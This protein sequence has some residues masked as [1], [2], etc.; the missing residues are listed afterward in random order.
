MY[1]VLSAD[2]NMRMWIGKNGENSSAN[3]DAAQQF[4]VTTTPITVT[5]PS[6]GQDISSIQMGQ[7]S[8]TGTM[9]VHSV[10]KGD[11]LLIDGPANNSQNWSDDVE[12]TSGV[13]SGSEANKAFDGDLSTQASTSGTNADVIQITFDPS[14]KDIS[15]F[16]VYTSL[17]ANVA[18]N[19]TSGDIN[20][21][22]ADNVQTNAGAWT[23][24]GINVNSN[25]TSLRVMGN[26]GGAA[27]RISAIRVDDKLLVDSGTEWD[28]SEVW[29][30]GMSGAWT[31]ASP[32]ANLY[33][34]DV[35]YSSGAQAE[36]N[37]LVTALSVDS[38]SKLTEV[39]KIE[40]YSQITGGSQFFD[41]IGYSDDGSTEVFNQKI[42]DTNN[43]SG[44]KWY[45]ISGLSNVDIQRIDIQNG[46]QTTRRFAALKING[47]ILVDAGTLGGNGFYLPFN[48]AESGTKWSNYLSTNYQL[49]NPGQSFD[50][51]TSTYGEG[52][53]VPMTILL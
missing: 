25:V 17:Q 35:E 42:N 6:D 9:R 51:N 45:V 19:V 26:A 46:D 39:T 2:T 49:N 28:Q 53:G 14:L 44:E 30:A 21:L 13:N 40:I 20:S 18:V 8:G 10:K 43:G 48:P 15:K 1:L 27:P 37:G 29:S 7:K 50:G 41:V 52:W 11:N 4:D 47:K 32:L 3:T 23:D 38:G 5:L 34:G 12:A 16:E 24:L 22:P 36:Q 31:A 33:D